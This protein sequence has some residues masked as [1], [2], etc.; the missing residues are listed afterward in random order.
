MVLRLI[1]LQPM[2][3]LG[4]LL[5]RFPDIQVELILIVD[6]AIPSVAFHLVLLSHKDGILGAG[7]F[8]VAAENAPEHVDHVDLGVSLAG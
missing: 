3:H 6:E 8:T 7:L 4:P 5:G 2:E 1:L